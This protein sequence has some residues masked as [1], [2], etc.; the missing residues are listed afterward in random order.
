MDALLEKVVSLSN[1]SPAGFSPQASVEAA[2][3]LPGLVV[4]LSL[5]FTEKFPWEEKQATVCQHENNDTYCCLL[6]QFD[7][8]EL[9]VSSTLRLEMVSVLASGWLRNMLE[10][11]ALAGFHFPSSLVFFRKLTYLRITKEGCY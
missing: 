2:E 4:N 10:P 3:L 5:S 7:S 11:G 1:S 9:E 8:G 6:F